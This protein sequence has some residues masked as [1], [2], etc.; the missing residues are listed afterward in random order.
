MEGFYQNGKRL[1]LRLRRAFWG[2]ARRFKERCGQAQRHLGRP[3]LL[4]DSIVG[5]HHEDEI[6]DDSKRFAAHTLGKK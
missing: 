3:D 2:E 4:I 6:D 1:D 5:Y